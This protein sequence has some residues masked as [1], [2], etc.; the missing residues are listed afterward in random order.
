MNRL[1][2]LLGAAVL[3]VALAP[4][5][6]ARSMVIEA[7]DVDI[8]IA[9]DATLHVEERIRVRFSGHWNG[10]FRDIPYGYV[11][12]SGVRG[13]IDALIDDVEDDAG[14][15]LEYWEER[16]GGEVKLKI[17]VPGAT[18]AVRTVVIRYRAR[19]AV[20]SYGSDD[21]PEFGAHDQLYWNAVG[22]AWQAPI[23]SS[24]TT[25]H[26]PPSLADAAPEAVKTRVFSGRYGAG[27]LFPAARREGGTL[28]FAAPGPLPPYHGM[29]IVVGFPTGHIEY[30][31]F[32]Q[33]ALWF[34]QA[35]WFLL[36][37]IA[38]L[39]LWFHLWWT[40]GRDALGHRTIIPEFEPPLGLQPAEVGVLLDERLDRHDV[41]AGIVGLAVKGALT[42]QD[43]DGERRL[44]LHPKQMA[45]ADLSVFE[46][47]LV[48]HLFA[49]DVKE[50]ELT[51][52]K[53]EFVKK[54]Q[55]LRHA[56][57]D[58]LVRRKLFPRRPDRVVSGWVGW[59]LLALLAPIALGLLLKLP[60]IYWV[61]LVGAAIGMFLFVPHMPRRTSRGLDALAR[62]RGM[63]EYMVTAEKQRMKSLPMESFERL[64]PY[65]IAF[66]IHDRWIAAFS[67]LFTRKPD[68]YDSDRAWTPHVFR[69]GLDSLRSDVGDSLYS[70]PRPAQTSGSG[71]WGGGWSGGSGFS[72]GGSS[73]GGFGGGGGGGW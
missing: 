6:W 40:R 46:K 4:A 49:D 36:I 29:T 71:G 44:I 54:L 27:T 57:L 20:R 52:L 16:R 12:P 23:E 30:P 55:S 48:G 3:A 62:V 59:T 38:L 32:L 56:V 22:H 63:Q 42:I 64:L 18:N 69:S 34:A 43:R 37:P 13:T 47:K 19:N 2:L 7:L 73:G 65:A 67:D 66:G 35:N 14:H 28:V 70:G 31:G 1:C 45:S 9:K 33:R 51:S 53:Y 72:G 24:R 11:Y 60:A 5:A 10:I 15:D 17:R 68:W 25:V 50:V 21:D 26:L 61:A 8:R 39:L 58:H 41:T